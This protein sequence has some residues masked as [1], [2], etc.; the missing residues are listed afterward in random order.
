MP[1]KNS[2]IFYLLAILILVAGIFFRFW[3]LDSVPPGIQYDEAYNGINAIQAFETGD[4]KIF[5]PENTG[6]EGLHINVIAIFIKFFGVSGFGL[7]FANALWG[8]LT[9]IGFYFL[10]RELKLSKLSVLLGV[11]MLG[12]SFW[13][14]DFSRTAFRA[15]MVPVCLVWA[16]YF[17]LK[18]LNGNNSNK[19][20]Y[21]FFVLA[22]F[23]LGLGFYSYIAFRVAPL[24]FIVFGIVYLCFE[25]KWLAKNW[26]AI[27]IFIF[28]AFFCA[29]PILLY[30]SSHVSDFLAR[31]QSI[32]VFHSSKLS[33][34][35]A[36]LKSLGIHLQAFFVHGDNN[37]R[38]NYNNQPLIP[39][40]W[41]AFFVLGFF[42]SLKEIGEN[43]IAKIKFKKNILSR[44]N[45]KP[46]ELFYPAVLAQSIFWVMLVPGILSIEGIPHSLR[47]IGTI[48]GVFLLCVF[49]IEYIL[50]IYRKM[51]DSSDVVLR[52]RGVNLILTFM[53]GLTAV[54][55]VS[56]FLQ[57]YTYFGLWAKD[58][59]TA[60]GF[61]RNLYLMG[62]LIKN[63]DAHKNN[64]VIT[65]QKTAI[66]ENGKT[67]S[68]KTTEYI[69]Y[70]KIKN[71]LFY[72]PAD[73]LNSVNCD[74]IQIVFQ[75][76]DQWLRDQY[77]AKCPNLQTDKY[78]FNKNKYIFYVMS[79]RE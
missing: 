47:I 46:S 55:M 44:E 71:Y 29:L 24:V 32:S 21:I 40:G 78:N 17:F 64:Y 68:L 15:I 60:G 34:G 6:R 38:H 12:F 8:S 70:P 72:R 61:E 36:L 42:I 18:G 19:K 48:P 45:F 63:L 20:V 11:F 73:G 56:G 74:D 14:L 30:F 22:G 43:I 28:T 62:M 31:S 76:S 23:F 25:K 69:A 79:S 13:H 58:L 57:V 3:K 7:R 16:L 75:E 10:L 27:S 35:Q 33:A 67:S 37:P 77:R 41:V 66:Y 54:I 9:L 50:K 49:P 1:T 5:Y 26:K 2:K 51:R 52:T 65:A 53:L 4:Y 39:A 59:R